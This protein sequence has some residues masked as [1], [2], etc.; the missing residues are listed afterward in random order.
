MEQSLV[1]ILVMGTG[2]TVDEGKIKS[3]DDKE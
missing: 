3:N 2:R 1:A